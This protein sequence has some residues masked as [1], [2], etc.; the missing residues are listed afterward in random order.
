MKKGNS[1]D[2]SNYKLIAIVFLL[3]TVME[4]HDR[5]YGFRHGRSTGDLVVLLT[6]CWIAAIESKEEG[7]VIS[8]D[9][10]AKAF[11]Q[12]WHGALLTKLPSYGFPE[13]LCK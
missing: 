13:N 10:A 3:S 9:W 2:L 12:V 4:D 5:Q 6:Y 7:L 11:Y 1:S 8:L